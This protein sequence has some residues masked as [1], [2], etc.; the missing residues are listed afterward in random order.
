MTTRAE[1]HLRGLL[2]ALASALRIGTLRLC[3]LAFSL[4]LLLLE[5]AHELFVATALDQLVLFRW[6]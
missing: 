6:R 5:F 1:R 3:L 4:E 2:R